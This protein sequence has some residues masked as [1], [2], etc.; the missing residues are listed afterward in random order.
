VLQS[1]ALIVSESD[2]RAPLDLDLPLEDDRRY[3]DTRIRIH[4]TR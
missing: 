1:G 3:G 4:A 2:H